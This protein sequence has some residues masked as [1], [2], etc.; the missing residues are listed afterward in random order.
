MTC[1]LCQLQYFWNDT[2]WPISYDSEWSCSSYND[3]SWCWNIQQPFFE[4]KYIRSPIL[5]AEDALLALGL[6]IWV[7]GGGDESPKYFEGRFWLN[8]G[9]GDLNK[10]QYKK[11][12]FSKQV[13]DIFT[14]SLKA[15]RTVEKS[16]GTV[17][18]CT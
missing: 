13:P 7:G 4:S 10:L 17:Q 14:P 6:R 12:T 11:S 8:R 1:R 2:Q 18:F 3:Q 5:Q 9:G 16:A 15:Y